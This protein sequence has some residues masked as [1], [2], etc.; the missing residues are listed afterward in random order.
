M[1]GANKVQ[2]QAISH[3]N[4]PALVVA[5]AGTGK[6]FVITQRIINLVNSGVAQPNEILALT[7][8]NKAATEMLER[9]DAEL[10][11]GSYADWVMTFHSFCERVLQENAIYFDIEPGYSLISEPEGVHL[12]KENIMKLSLSKFRPNWKKYYYVSEIL[13]FFSKLKDENIDESEF[14]N[15]V[16]D[17]ILS[18]L[19]SQKSKSK[20]FETYMSEIG[21]VRA[22]K[23]K[24]WKL[25]SSL[26]KHE[27]SHKLF[28]ELYSN[29]VP[30]EWE[31][32][33][34]YLEL[35]IVQGEYQELKASLNLMDFSDLIIKTIRL[36]Q[37]NPAVLE[38]Y[39]KQFKF[40]LVDEFQDTNY[41]QYVLLKMLCNE[42]RNIMVVGDDDQSIYKFR[43][44]SVANILGF[45]KDFPESQIFVLTDN[46]RSN[47]EILDFAYK[48]ISYNNPDR[49][50][51]REKLVKKL[52]AV[53]QEESLPVKIVS[54]MNE[55][56]EADY[57]ANEIKEM[58]NKSDTGRKSLF[59]G[60]YKYSDIAVLARS[61]N[62]V[63][64]LTKT[65]SRHGIPFQFAG[66]K[67]LFNTPEIIFLL[68]FIS[69][70]CDFEDDMHA[71][72]ML[73]NVFISVGARDFEIINQQSRRDK[74]SVLF[75]LE[76]QM[77]IRMGED[78]VSTVAGGKLNLYRVSSQTVTILN[79]IFKAVSKALN[80]MSE[81]LP[82]ENIIIDMLRELG[83]AQR[84]TKAN[85]LRSQLQVRNIE[86]FLSLVRSYEVKFGNTDI[87][88]FLRYIEATRTLGYQSEDER[89]YM[90][91]DTVNVLTVHKAKGLEF[92]VVFVAGLVTR[93]F[94]SDNRE[95]AIKVPL[96]LIKETEIS[97]NFHIQ[98]ERRLFY[99]AVTRAKERLYLTYSMG[100]D[101]GGRKKKP[102]IFLEEVLTDGGVALSVERI[103]NGAA[104]LD[105]AIFETYKDQGV[106]TSALEEKIKGNLN[107]R[108]ISYSYVS[109][110]NNCP[111]AFKLKY[112]LNL[113]TK[114]NPIFFYGTCMHNVLRQMFAYLKDTGKPLEFIKATDILNSLWNKGVF[115]SREEEEKY[116]KNSYRAL[117]LFYD[118]FYTGEEQPLY[119][120]ET[121]KALV[122]NVV[123]SG[124]FDR[125]DKLGEDF[126]IID[127]KTGQLKDPELVKE[128]MQLK[129]YAYAFEKMHNVKAKEASLLFVD[130]GSEIVIKLDE[131]FYSRLEG[132]LK[133]F[134]DPTIIGV[135]AGKFDAT[136]GN[137][138]KFCAYQEICEFAENF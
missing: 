107:T 42:E 117:K 73:N 34:V 130:E 96:E 66:S 113:P 125:I 32:L 63:Q 69:V 16:M 21:V 102:S 127:Y 67:N 105:K 129:I 15:W 45:R 93:R 101:T 64:T 103:D 1:V 30:S 33:A 135:I 114:D 4:G 134:I 118:K 68:S 60:K 13:S 77:G 10:P 90:D 110:Y 131:A 108:F 74:Q 98:E 86:R 19:K 50:E 3:V 2:Q 20:L 53:N 92:P 52:R 81:E 82:I 80:Q 35:A 138:C 71:L 76:E 126:K 95:A 44:A 18:K 27:F 6:T 56:D 124:R 121:F 89:D 91:V 51:I 36:F 72:K 59:E 94:P 39:R 128:D 120:E 87:R 23:D 38:R 28:S 112:I 46:Y 88:Q 11:I 12:F 26:R 14:L 132:E 137:S 5:G 29:I 133:N 55:F 43:G 40:I 58:I 7:F 8:T 41:S 49:L 116:R 54:S 31:E 17:K 111:Y 119:L 78:P 106:D 100:A 62:H 115:D 37:S 24:G 84:L 83:I 48:S 47:Q 25:D 57:I 70:L 85:N 104:S 75:W 97:E 9:I 109:S 99:V 65:F 22:A 123:L 122:G 136:P 79:G 61:L